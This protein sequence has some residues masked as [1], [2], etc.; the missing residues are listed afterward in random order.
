MEFYPTAQ[1]KITE[2]D[3]RNSI[4]MNAQNILRLQISV[5]NSFK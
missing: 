3:R 2:F 5:R 4:R 1:V